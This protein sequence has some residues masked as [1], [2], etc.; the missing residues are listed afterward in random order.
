MS[1]SFADFFRLDI[2]LGIVASLAWAT[3]LVMAVLRWRAFRQRADVWWGLAYLCLLA[4]GIGRLWTAATWW[5]IDPDGWPPMDMS[6]SP[7]TMSMLDAGKLAF[8]DLLTNVLFAAAAVMA[9]FANR[10]RPDA[11]DV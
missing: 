6:V 5:S 1:I 10:R 9:A 2:A 7:D 3:C 8:V 4:V 11:F